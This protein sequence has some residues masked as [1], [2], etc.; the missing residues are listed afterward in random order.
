VLPF[1]WDAFDWAE[2]AAIKTGTHPETSTL[3]NI[4]Q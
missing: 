2:N 1:G 3:G 4:N